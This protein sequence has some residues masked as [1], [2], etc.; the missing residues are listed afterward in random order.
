MLSENLLDSLKQMLFALSKA[1]G[2]RVHTVNVFSVEQ[3]FNSQYKDVLSA[4]VFLHD[5]KIAHRDMK[6]ENILI[7][8][9]VSLNNI[10]YI[11]KAKV[12]IA[13]N[14]PRS[15]KTVP[16]VVFQITD[17]GLATYV[18]GPLDEM[19]STPT[20]VAPEVLSRSGYTYQVDIWSLGVIT[21]ILLSG[22]PP[23]KGP[24]SSNLSRVQNLDSRF[25][26]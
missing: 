12:R 10:S 26:T 11:N 20:Y 15:C 22:F 18:Y 2:S 1:D 21:Y 24:E 7:E 25:Q 16:K 4:L 19:C 14:S 8:K 23:F 5:R 3:P 6:P 9:K 17:F 13:K